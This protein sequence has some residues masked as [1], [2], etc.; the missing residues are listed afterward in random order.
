MS[1]KV[2]VIYAVHAV[3]LAAADA[4]DEA[5]LFNSRVSHECRCMETERGMRETLL[6]HICKIMQKHL[7]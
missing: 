1:S 3:N 4:G 5:M 7:K 2:Y 6:A